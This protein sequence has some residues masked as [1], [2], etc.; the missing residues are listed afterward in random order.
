M[1]QSKGKE[2]IRVLHP[3]KDKTWVEFHGTSA[4][5]EDILKH[6]KLL[7]RTKEEVRADALHDIKLNNYEH[8]RGL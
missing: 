2:P 5:Q 1:P 4:R 7:T 8:T 6:Y 3:S